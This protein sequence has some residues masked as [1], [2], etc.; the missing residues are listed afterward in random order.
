MSVA[1]HKEILRKA[2]AAF[3]RIDDRSGWFDVHSE[4]IR[5]HGLAPTALDKAGMKGFYSALW[6][7]FPDLT[8]HI[9][10]LVGEGE[11]VVWR[12]VASGTH[13]GPFQGVQAT[14]KSVN[15]GAHYTFRFENGKIAERWSTIDRIA[16]LVQLG[17]ISLPFKK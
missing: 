17:A 14:G 11:L 16:V 8:I 9:D 2:M 6:G 1:E 3:N 4:S 10:E 15:F 7:G 13:N 5:A 12:I